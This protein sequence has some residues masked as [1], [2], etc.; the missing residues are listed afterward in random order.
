MRPL[1]T[2]YIPVTIFCNLNCVHCNI[3]KTRLPSEVSLEKRCEFISYIGKVS[4]DTQVA[5]TGGEPFTRP[6]IL[7]KLLSTSKRTSLPT[8]VTTNGTL[9]TRELAEKAVREGLQ[10][11]FIS[12]DSHLP[13]IHDRIKGVPGTF[14]KAV[15]AIK[16]FQ[17]VKKDLNTN[18]KIGINAILGSWNMESLDKLV[19]YF[20]DELKIEVITFNPL[21][22]VEP[23]HESLLDN[24]HFP[25][26]PQVKI[27]INMLKTLRFRSSSVSLSLDDLEA[28]QQYFFSPIVL[29]KPVC[30]S[31]ERNLVVGFNG[32]VSLCTM[33]L[34]Q[35]IGNIITDSFETILA[36]RNNKTLLEKMA[37]CKRTCGLA[38]CNRKSPYKEVPPFVKKVVLRYFPSFI[39][40][41][42]RF[43]LRN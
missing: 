13:E 33:G 6:D 8:L 24:P 5:L 18:L 27:G 2:L 25:S 34:F 38:S 20:Q 16:H 42:N 29:E 30:E 39:R 35:P 40:R 41:F 36:G 7:Y 32:D 3:W 23:S 19:E 1:E 15:Q 10:T 17:K 37:N 11:I 26:F 4:P 21:Q 9:V 12:L 28:F 43:L 22:S 14:D 31:A